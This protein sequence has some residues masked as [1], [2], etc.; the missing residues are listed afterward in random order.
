[1][2]ICISKIDFNDYINPEPIPG[3]II[4]KKKLYT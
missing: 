4:L 3:T 2:G 1:M